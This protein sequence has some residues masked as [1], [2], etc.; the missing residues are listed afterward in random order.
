MATLTQKSLWQL[1]VCGSTHNPNSVDQPPNVSKFNRLHVV[2]FWFFFN[3][4]RIFHRLMINNFPKVF[5][6]NQLFLKL[7]WFI[8][9][10]IVLSN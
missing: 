2:I 10:Y 6:V 3:N 8:R 7:S 9:N 5:N 4:L 1:Q